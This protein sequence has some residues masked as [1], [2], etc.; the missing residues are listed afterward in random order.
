[1]R[2][3]RA[4]KAHLK[5]LQRS[6]GCLVTSRL[7]P[8]TVPGRMSRNPRCGLEASGP[9]PSSTPLGSSSSSGIYLPA[10]SKHPGMPCLVGNSDWAKGS[11]CDLKRPIRMLPWPVLGAV[12]ALQGGL[13][14]QERRARLR[15]SREKHGLSP[16]T[17]QHP[18]PGARSYPHSE[19]FPARFPSSKPSEAGFLAFFTSFTCLSAFPHLPGLFFCLVCLFHLLIIL[20][21]SHHNALCSVTDQATPSLS[22]LCH[23]TCPICAWLFMYRLQVSPLLSCR[24]QKP[25]P[26][27]LRHFPGPSALHMV[28][29]TST[30]P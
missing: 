10:H 14:A 17:S 7:G 16:G 6:Q 27:L 11:T 25:G 3:R 28:G 22:V 1:M 8:S 18:G 21:S 23:S 4:G 2:G 9:D 5:P 30:V 12:T 20:P 19:P 24:G 13:S 15:G 29:F 26:R